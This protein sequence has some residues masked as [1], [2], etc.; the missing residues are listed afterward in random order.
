[1]RAERGWSFFCSF[2]LRPF[3][4]IA[5]ATHFTKHVAPLLVSTRYTDAFCS[6]LPRKAHP[7]DVTSGGIAAMASSK[8]KRP[9]CQQRRLCLSSPGRFSAARPLPSTP[10]LQDKGVATSAAAALFAFTTTTTKP[11]NNKTPNTTQT[12][13]NKNENSLIT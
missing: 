13:N 1:M 11:N 8:I 12:T 4:R 9:Y 6:P 5:H 10:L 3:R 2:R 7:S